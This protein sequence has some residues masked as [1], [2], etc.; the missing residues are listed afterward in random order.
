MINAVT[1]TIMIFIF[2]GVLKYRLLIAMAH[3]KYL[4]LI[5]IPLILEL[6]IFRKLVL[7][8][9]LMNQQFFIIS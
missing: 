1:E 9:Y 2:Q 7:I 6:I 8:E 3:R 5:L 4:L